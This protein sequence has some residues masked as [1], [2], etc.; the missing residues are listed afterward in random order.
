MKRFVLLIFVLVAHIAISSV[1]N[2]QTAFIGNGLQIQFVDKDFVASSALEV[3][4]EFNESWAIGAMA[5]LS[6]QVDNTLVAGMGV[7][8]YVRYTPI[9]NDVIFLDLKTAAR[10]QYFTTDAKNFLIGVYPSLRFRFAPRWEAFTDIGFFGARF[11]DT[12]GWYPLLGFNP[13]SAI[14]GIIYRFRQ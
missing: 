2:A 4:Y 9:H 10:G 5:A 8:G 6:A 3:G 13:Q 12:Y 11:T 7:G 14:V 1:A